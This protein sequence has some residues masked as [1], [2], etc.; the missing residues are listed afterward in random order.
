VNWT[1]GLDAHG[2]PVNPFVPEESGTAPLTCPGTAG[3]RNFNHSAYSARLGWWFTSSTEMCT[4][5]VPGP[6][7]R[8]GR[9]PNPDAPPHI[10]AFDPLTGKEQ[11]RFATKY[12]NQ[13]SLLVTAGDL[14]FGGDMDGDAFALDARTGRKL[15]S[16][17]TG[18]RI[19]SPPVA[20]SVNGRQ[21]VAIGSGGGSGRARNDPRW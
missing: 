13:S 1:K 21:F 7:L 17:N 18:G 2:K 10:S 9:A 16:F 14:I 11:W 4:R 20:F 8:A 6:D 3:A 12:V 5:F 19:V 15:W